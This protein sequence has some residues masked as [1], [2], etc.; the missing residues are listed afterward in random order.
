M[1]KMWWVF[2]GSIS[3]ASAALGQSPASA[4]AGVDPARVSS[5]LQTRLLRPLARAES[6]RSPFS[7]EEPGPEERRVRLLD[8]TPRRDTRGEAFVRFAVDAR[9]AEEATWEQNEILGC[10]YPDTRRVF[11][12]FGRAHVPARALLGHDG[13]ARGDVCRAAPPPR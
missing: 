12:Q 6:K 11:V 9:W 2:L 3:L 7:R 8:S 4:G 10:V 1:K 13:A 5:L